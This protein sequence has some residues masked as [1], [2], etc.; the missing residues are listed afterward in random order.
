MPSGSLRGRLTTSTSDD[1]GGGGGGRGNDG[2]Q[3]LTSSCLTDNSC[4][5]CR[6]RSCSQLLQ[7]SEEKPSTDKD[8]TTNPLT[9]K[10]IKQLPTTAVTAY[11]NKS[12]AE[13]ATSSRHRKR[14]R[15]RRRKARLNQLTS[16]RLTQL[17]SRQL[18]GVV[19][20]LNESLA[21]TPSS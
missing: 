15:R 18:G 3:Q 11:L 16:H 1:A 21:A 5:C 2:D 8:S 9:I 10:L 13:S 7:D 4:P 12:A 19:G 6:S 14:G 17:R 20:V